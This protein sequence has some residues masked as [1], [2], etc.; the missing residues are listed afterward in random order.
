MTRLRFAK[1]RL[2][3]DPRVGEGVN[4]RVLLA[5]YLCKT[6]RFQRPAVELPQHFPLSV[7]DHS[8]KT[9]G[10]FEVVHMFTTENLKNKERI[11]HT[12]FCVP[13]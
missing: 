5:K 1:R 8:L 7:P 13:T 4:V 12:I 9:M 6:G 3:L 10:V 2:G 11:K